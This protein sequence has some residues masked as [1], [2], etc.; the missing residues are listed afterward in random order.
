[1]NSYRYAIYAKIYV[2]FIWNNKIFLKIVYNKKVTNS[3]FCCIYM[4]K[5]PLFDNNM[6]KINLKGGLR[7]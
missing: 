2:D 6:F 4:N 5:K 7:V 3:P 1:M